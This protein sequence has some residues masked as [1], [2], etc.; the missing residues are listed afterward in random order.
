M[1]N[2]VIPA[3]PGFGKRNVYIC[4]F[5]FPLDSAGVAARWGEFDQIDEIVVYS[6]SVK[7]HF[8][9]CLQRLKIPHKN[10]RVIFPPVALLPSEAGLKIV[11]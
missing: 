2:E 3:F 11:R 10:L 8:A 1:G 5:P 9:A 6:D 4:Q 7:E